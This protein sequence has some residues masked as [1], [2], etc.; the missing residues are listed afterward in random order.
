MTIEWIKSHLEEDWDC[1]NMYFEVTPEGKIIKYDLTSNLTY[2][3]DIARVE[4]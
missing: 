1:D 2:E 4:N 3:Y